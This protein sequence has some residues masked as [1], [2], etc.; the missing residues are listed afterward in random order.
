M[1][2]IFEKFPVLEL[3]RI[4]LREIQT[5]DAK[6]FFDYTNNPK[7]N[8]FLPKDEIPNSIIQAEEELSYWARLFH[9]RHCVYWAIELKKDSRFIGTCGFH[10]WSKTHHRGEISYDLDYNYWG[11][12]YTT[13]AI[14]AIIEYGF[15]KMSMIRIQATAAV[16]NYPSIR[17]LEKNG[18]L[19]EGLMKN[20]GILHDQVKDFYLFSKALG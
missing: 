20:Y 1:K 4:I 10:N 16:D 8:A 2:N 14:K 7:V 9:Y 17:V 6:K 12:G 13:E 11:N 5:S 3:D 18:F 19:K 15:Y